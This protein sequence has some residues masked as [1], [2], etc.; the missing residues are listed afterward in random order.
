[1]VKFHAK[2]LLEKKKGGERIRS[3]IPSLADNESGPED[4]AKRQIKKP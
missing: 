3:R 1:L 4:M 2:L